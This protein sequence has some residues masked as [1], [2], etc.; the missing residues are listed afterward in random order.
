[1]KRK[2]I[3]QAKRTIPWHTWFRW[4]DCFLC[5]KQFRR[6]RGFVTYTQVAGGKVL[7]GAKYTCSTCADSTLDAE[8]K[9]W[10]KIKAS[11]PNPP[12]VPPKPRSKHEE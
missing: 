12:K 10:D 7:T 8:K 4:I 3:P 11:R 2:L 9:T 5:E 6:E 1:M